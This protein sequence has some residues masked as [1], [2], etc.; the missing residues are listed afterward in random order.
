MFPAMWIFILI[1][2]FPSQIDTISGLAKKHG[3]TL[4]GFRNFE[5]AVTKEMIESIREHVKL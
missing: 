4:A 1:L 2:A 5:H 3:F